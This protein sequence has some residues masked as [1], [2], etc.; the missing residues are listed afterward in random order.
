MH[1]CLTPIH[2]LCKQDTWLGHGNHNLQLI[3]TQTL[4]CPRL[5][6]VIQNTASE[7]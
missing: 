6:A 4:K 1:S 2:K 7:D 5:L 3:D